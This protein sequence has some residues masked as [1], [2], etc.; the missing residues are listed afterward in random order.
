MECFG[1]EEAGYSRWSEL[2]DTAVLGLGLD[3]SYGRS[4]VGRRALG[5][6]NAD[7][8]HDAGGGRAA[9]ATLIT[10][11]R[12]D[13]EVFGSWWSSSSTTWRLNATGSRSRLHEC[14]RPAGRSRSSVCIPTPGGVLHAPVGSCPCGCDWSS[15]PPLLVLDPLAD[16]PR[17][18]DEEGRRGGD[19]E[20]PSTPRLGSHPNGSRESR[21][22][23]P[24]R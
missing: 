6:T 4:D 11:R 1:G 20:P 14:M 16:H 24:T 7:G 2:R 9:N 19:V 3:R 23:R 13:L 10:R 17:A 22:W 18:A 21:D 5:Q 12:E 15:G 8:E